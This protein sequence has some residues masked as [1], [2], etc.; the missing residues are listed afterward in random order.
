[1]K[2]NHKFT[3]KLQHKV[4]NDNQKAMVYTAQLN[5]DVYFWRE[6][7]D[8]TYIG[9]IF[10]SASWKISKHSEKKFHGQVA[11]HG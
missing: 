9:I 8:A 4:A 5:F 3:L 7:L 1:M 10:Y 2:T 6:K 11:D